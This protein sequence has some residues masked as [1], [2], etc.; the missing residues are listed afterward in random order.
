MFACRDFCITKYETQGTLCIKPHDDLLG[1]HLSNEGR[2]DGERFIKELS[3]KIH[4]LNCATF[5]PFGGHL[6]DGMTPGIGLARLVCHTLLI[7]S[8]QGL[9]LIDTGL[10][11]RDI[12]HPK[13]R[14]NSF[15]K[16]LVRPV[17]IENE[18]AYFQIKQMGFHPKDVRHI[19]LTHLDFDHAGGL[20]DFPNAMVHVMEAERRA[21]KNRNTFVAR[22]RYSL[23]QL[24]Q[25][26]HW[27][28]Y[29]PEGERWFGFQSVRDLEGLPPEILL[30]PLYGHTEGHAGV[31]IKTDAGWLLHAGDAYF[32]HGE[33]DTTYHCTP[34]LRAYQKFMAANAHL[35]MSNQQR[36][37]QLS[38]HHKD[39]TIFCAH[40]AVEYLALKE[41]LTMN[42]F[43]EQPRKPNA[44]L[45]G[46]GLS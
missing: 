28:T 44:D 7:E 32:F 30:I 19:I 24:S 36:L 39:V 46:M 11:M 41:G 34:G 4:H 27:N 43:S 45:A 13:D 22:G 17:L 31:A 29:F 16:N 6:M 33:M 20:D 1:I 37:R 12:Q 42:L 3:M 14:I 40:D 23:P 21:T 2:D 10:G 35:R 15:F 18:T 9:I 5:C 38:H 26:K 8:E 25:E